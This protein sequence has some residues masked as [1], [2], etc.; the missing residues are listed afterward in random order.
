MDKRDGFIRINCS[1]GKT[2]WVKDTSIIY[3]NVDL[4]VD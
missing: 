4:N 3:P 1:G 2:I